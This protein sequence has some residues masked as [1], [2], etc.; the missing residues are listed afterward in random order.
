MAD[1][2]FSQY[3]RLSQEQTL[4]PQI[5]RALNLLQ[6]PSMDLQREVAEELAK[7]PLLEMEDGGMSSLE[8]PLPENPEM[9][10]ARARGNADA[11][12]PDG[13]AP[14]AARDDWRERDDAPP[15]ET[16]VWTRDDDER[17]SRL[18]NSLVEHAS[19]RDMLDEQIALADVPES[20]RRILSGIADRLDEKGFLEGDADALATELGVPAADAEKAIA[21]FQTFDPPGIGA[22]DLRELFMIQL[23][24]NGREK[25]LA[26][27]VVSE[28]YDALL[29]RKFGAIADKFG[30]SDS[31]LRD[32]VAE[33]ARV[34]RVPAKDFVADENREVFPDLT[35]YF[36]E[37]TGEWAAKSNFD[38]VPKLRISPAYKALLAQ[39]KLS[40]KDRAYFS[41]KTRD[42]KSLINALDERRRTI[43]KIGAALAKFL[44]PFFEKGPAALPSLTMADVAAEIGMHE[45]T[46]SRAV[47]NKYAETPWGVRELRKFFNAS[48]P[49]DSG[50]SISNAGV[51]EVLKEILENEPSASPLSDEKLAEELGRRGIRVARRTIAKYRGMLGIPP[52]HLR[53]KF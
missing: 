30:V 28:A 39:G 11:G 8:T 52:A 51:R 6:A 18:F 42:A 10:G 26:F 14:D 29:A 25:S 43:E 40:P 36:D 19:L 1:L 2:G 53:R 20:E 16:R 47:A 23:R 33:I 49:T 13:D 15:G 22:R 32:A 38:Y 3:Q 9:P 45:T 17:R 27:R 35:F 46:V 48:L 44:R 31:A 7:N 24:R 41:E 12:T 4:S 5:I 37:K 34:N 21:T 50:G